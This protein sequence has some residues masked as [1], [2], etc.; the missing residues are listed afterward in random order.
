M[1]W[2]KKWT[3]TTRSQRT[4]FFL[5]PFPSASLARFLQLADTKV[6]RH[7]HFSFLPLYT[8]LLL[9]YHTSSYITFW[10]KKWTVTQ[11]HAHNELIFFWDLFPHLSLIV[12]H[13]SQQQIANK[14]LK[15]KVCAESFF[16]GTARPLFISRPSFLRRSHTLSPNYSPGPGRG[17]RIG[18]IHID[19]CSPSLHHFC[20]VQLLSVLPRT[21]LLPAHEYLHQDSGT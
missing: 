5:G 17:V 18:R 14:K 2:Y 8:Q 12:A 6:G 19:H 13:P 16:D 10:Y 4:D 9:F 20:F 11:R 7:E 3:V 21:A 1:I 15:F